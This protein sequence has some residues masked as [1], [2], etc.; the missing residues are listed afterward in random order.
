MHVEGANYVK[1]VV[2]NFPVAVKG[3]KCVIASN[4]P[5]GSGLSSSAAL[6]A[7]VFLLLESLSGSDTGLS[8]MDKAKVC[9]KSEH[10]FAGV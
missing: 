5:I 3:F 8:N 7:A 6:E 9:Q 1:G 10:D 2:A 4:I